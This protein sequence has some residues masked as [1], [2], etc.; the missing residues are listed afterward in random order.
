MV[1]YNLRLILDHRVIDTQKQ[2][3]EPAGN[4]PSDRVKKVQPKGFHYQAIFCND[5]S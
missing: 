4:F 5:E 3:L 2:R 1:L